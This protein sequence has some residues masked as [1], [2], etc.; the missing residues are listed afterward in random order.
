VSRLTGW[1]RGEA[2][3]PKMPAGDYISHESHPPGSGPSASGIIIDGAVY[4]LDG[5]PP[6]ARGR[7]WGDLG[8]L[9]SPFYHRGHL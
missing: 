1:L 8:W 4:A 9:R 6:V 2:R 5:Q 7:S 3:Q